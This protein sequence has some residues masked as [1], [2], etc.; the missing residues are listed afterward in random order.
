MQQLAPFGFRPAFHTSGQ[1]NPRTQMGFVNSAP[2]KPLYQNQPVKIDTVT[3]AIT[4]IAAITDQVFAVFTGLQYVDQN[5]MV[6][7]R[8]FVL[9]G[10]P[11][12][13]NGGSENNGSAYTNIGMPY[14][15]QDPDMEYAVQANGPMTKASVG[16][17]YNLDITTILNGSASGISGALLNN[18]AVSGGTGQ[19][20]VT[21]LQN[22]PNNV[23]G[24]PY[25]VVKV[26]FNNIL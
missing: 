15:Y 9:A 24:D 26:K 5:G 6:K 14:L 20:I 25:T 21:E 22:I 13:A 19:F 11:F 8:N 17:T 12:F 18:V 10:T 3:G 16:Q 23:W 7:E 1:A 4:P 2:T